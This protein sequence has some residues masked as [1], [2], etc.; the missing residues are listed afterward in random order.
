MNR[1]FN[2]YKELKEIKGIDKLNTSKV[3]NIKGIICRCNK[4][5]NLDLTNFDT[6]NIT[7]MEGVFVG[8]G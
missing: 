2:E 6:S 7:N 4:L 5:I 1:V 8:F 3:T